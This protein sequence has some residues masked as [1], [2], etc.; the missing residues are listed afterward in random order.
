MWEALPLPDILTAMKS[1]GVPLFEQSRRLHG[2]FVRVTH[3]NNR[4][5]K[6]SGFAKRGDGHS[7]PPSPR[8]SND[9]AI[10]DEFKFFKETA[11]NSK[12]TTVAD[13]FFEDHGKRLKHPKLPLINV[14]SRQ[15]PVYIPPEL[16]IV[17]SQ[18]DHRSKLSPGA[19]ADMIKFAVRSAP[20]NAVTITGNNLKL[21]QQ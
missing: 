10:S 2:V 16:C 4:L 5:K 6:I 20:V 19:T 15:R 1:E 11:T 12:W 9:A 3:L 17:K 7:E 13:H 8:S 14:G 21:L 18:Q